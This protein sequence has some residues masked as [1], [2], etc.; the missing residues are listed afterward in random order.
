MR[1]GVAEA[2]LLGVCAEEEDFFTG[3][4]APITCCLYY[5]FFNYL[6][7]YLFQRRVLAKIYLFQRR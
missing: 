2:S 4:V 5:L 7:V 3:V 1:L 6:Y